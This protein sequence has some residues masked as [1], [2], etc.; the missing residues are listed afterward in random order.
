MT[1]MNAYDTTLYAKVANLKLKNPLLKVF[2]SVGGWD[3]GG[4]IFSDMVSTADNRAA[5]ITSAIQF[6]R[7]F[8]FDGVDI[9]WE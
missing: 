3:A 7:T 9:D 2:I 6:C 4:K 8:A 5:F 1:Q